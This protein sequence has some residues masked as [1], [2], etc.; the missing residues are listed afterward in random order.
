MTDIETTRPRR[1]VA[2]LFRWI[3]FLALLGGAVLLGSILQPL[4]DIVTELIATPTF[5]PTIV[6][7]STPT[8]LPTESPRLSYRLSTPSNV[9]FAVDAV[10]GV[11]KVT[12]DGSS[13][14][15]TQ[16]S[17]TNNIR[18]ALTAIYPDFSLGPFI[19]EADQSSFVFTSL[20]AHRYKSVAVSIRALGTIQIGAYQYEFMSDAVM[21]KDIEWVTPTSTLTPTN[22]N[23]PTSTGTSTPSATS[24]NTHTP[25]LTPS[26]TNTPSST[27]TSTSTFTP[28]KTVT[29]KDTPTPTATNT[30][31]ATHTPTATLTFTATS[32]PTQKRAGFV[33]IYGDSG[34]LKFCVMT[35]SLRV[36]S[37]PGGSIVGRLSKGTIIDVDLATKV[38]SEGYVWAKHATGWSAL[39]PLNNQNQPDIHR[40]SVFAHPK[41]CPSAT[42]TRTVAPTVARVARATP[43]PANQGAEHDRYGRGDSFQRRIDSQIKGYADAFAGSL[44]GVISGTR[45]CRKRA[46][47]TNVTNCVIRQAFF[48]SATLDEAIDKAEDFLGKSIPKMQLIEHYVS[49]GILDKDFDHMSKDEKALVDGL[50]DWDWCFFEL[51]S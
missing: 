41:E 44:C 28:S 9:Q 36:R 34:I 14:M 23:T 49:R 32:T 31:T 42:P 46:L 10:N 48:D 6:P 27:P 8:R 12:W 38:K 40:I 7:T 35:D 13:W 17:E 25:T 19:A 50:H 33:G 26:D 51:E 3:L 43:A 2:R 11:G 37:S 22:T 1:I 30:H 29:P 15:P 47:Y 4:T 5:T 39:Y 21:S 45:D 24:T 20:N 16:P 18:Y